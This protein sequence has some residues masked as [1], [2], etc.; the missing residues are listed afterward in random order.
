MRVRCRPYRPSAKDPSLVAKLCHSTRSMKSA[1]ASSSWSRSR[2]SEGR[3]DTST[4]TEY[5]SAARSEGTS[6]SAAT[7]SKNVGRSSPPSDE[8][9]TCIARALLGADNRP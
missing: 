3:R 1:K 4:P 5:N 7:S 9:G 8:G 6:L 2:A